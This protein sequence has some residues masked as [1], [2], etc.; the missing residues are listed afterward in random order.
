[1]EDGLEAAPAEP[2][3]LHFTLELP[4]IS[5]LDLDIIK[6]TAQYVAR[7]GKSFEATLAKKEAGQI[8]FDFLKP[9][10]SLHKLYLRLIDQFSLVMLPPKEVLDRV[11]LCKDKFGLLEHIVKER[12]EYAKWDQARLQ[13]AEADATR[14]R[15][16]YGRVAWND[17]VVVETI[18][19]TTTDRDIA[20]PKPMDLPTVSSLSVLQRQELWSGSLLRSI[21]TGDK[22][23]INSVD[24]IGDDELPPATAKIPAR[25]GVPENVNVRYDYQ[26]KAAMASG[27]KDHMV[28]CSICGRQMPSSQLQEHM[29]VELLDSKWAEQRQAHLAKHVDTNIVESGTD[30][31]L[32]LA[33]L[34]K[35]RTPG[36]R[37]STLASKVI[38]DGSADSVAAANREASIKGRDEIQRQVE[39]LQRHTGGDLSLDP[40][41][42]I[43]PRI[44]GAYPQGAPYAYAPYAYPPQMPPGY[45]PQG[46]PQPGYPP[47][48]YAYPPGYPGYPPGYYPAQPGPPGQPAYP[49]PPYGLSPY[50]HQ[51]PPPPQQPPKQ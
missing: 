11:V 30:V 42:G 44:P 2:G 15:E 45:P 4:N 32:N 13:K 20:L 3:P 51:G 39:Q 6:L 7:N 27:P 26:P 19:F 50:P 48:G 38:W 47:Q 41:T 1:V 8:Q 22:R 24:E 31:S 43:G 5:P 23:T 34:A 36:D 16:E 49:Q 9:G 14:E 18:D 21:T 29:R 33:A 10:H 28:A 12:V 17:F 46:Y 40:S 37:Q 25:A 35:N